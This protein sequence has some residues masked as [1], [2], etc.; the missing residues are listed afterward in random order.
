MDERA[1]RVLKMALAEGG[2]DPPGRANKMRVFSEWMVAHLVMHHPTLHKRAS[3]AEGNAGKT[4]SG[5]LQDRDFRSAVKNCPRGVQYLNW[6]D[7]VQDIGNLGSH[8]Q[9][10]EQEVTAEYVKSTCPQFKGAVEWFLEHH[11]QVEEGFRSK[12]PNASKASQKPSRGKSGHGTGRRGREAWYVAAVAAAGLVALVAWWAVSGASGRSATDDRDVAASSSAGESAEDDDA[13]VVTVTA[14]DAG[15]DSQRATDAEPDRMFG[16]PASPAGGGSGE[17][18]EEPRESSEVLSVRPSPVPH[19]LN[20]DGFA[21]VAVGADR[22]DTPQSDVGTVFVHFGLNGDPESASREQHAMPNPVGGAGF[23]TAVAVGGD[24]NGDGIADL[25]VGAPFADVRG[26]VRA[27]GTGTAF[28]FHGSSGR[29]ESEFVE[30]TWDD[31]AHDCNFGASVAFGGDFNGDTVN[32]L[33]VSAPGAPSGSVG[34]GV[35]LVYAG[36][37]DSGSTRRAPAFVVDY[38]GPADRKRWGH[39]LAFV[40]DLDGD[41]CD[42]LLIGAPLHFLVVRAWAGA[43]FLAFGSRTPGR[44]RSVSTGIRGDEKNAFLGAALA[45]GRRRSRASNQLLVVGAPGEN[46]GATK[47]GVVY[48]YSLVPRSSRVPPNGFFRLEARLLCP[49]AAAND[50]FG[51]AVAVGDANG[52]GHDDV[53][54]GAPGRNASFNDQGQVYLFSGTAARNYDSHLVIALPRPEENAAFGK[55]LALVGDFNGDGFD[56]FVVGADNQNGLEDSASDAGAAYLFLG[57]SSLPG[58]IV[59]LPV[60]SVQAGARYGRLAWVLPELN[61]SG[62]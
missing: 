13:A 59:P 42:E 6:L 9:P 29:S 60:A 36:A 28:L 46:G 61:G 55:G 32:D 51:T 41:G 15:V 45:V 56:D 62:Y 34:R 53:L 5:V 54:V 37:R 4:K 20:G 14:A 33:A 44:L 24:A 12:G 38:P 47:A 21:D 50:F 31:C 16:P 2:G 49:E 7:A 25:L 26:A 8:W 23:G 35:V 39:A 43:V 22:F 30:L 11:G 40:D 27:G 19:D 58:R 10:E 48:V 1:A 52:D 57:A 17:E 3:S 18:P